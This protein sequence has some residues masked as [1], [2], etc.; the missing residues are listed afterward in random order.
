MALY[1]VQEETMSGW[2]NNW[3]YTDEFNKDY[4]TTFKDYESA[5]AEL[6]W[7]ITN[8]REEYEAGNLEDYPEISQFKIVKVQ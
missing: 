4:P 3:H 5:H 7:F 1:E 2:V 6:L 8:M